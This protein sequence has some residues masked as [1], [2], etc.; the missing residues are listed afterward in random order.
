MHFYLMSHTHMPMAT[1]AE[2]TVVEVT[3][4]AVM[5][6]VAGGE[7]MATVEEVTVRPLRHQLFSF[8]PRLQFLRHLPLPLHHRHLLRLQL[9]L[10]PQF[11]QPLLLHQDVAVGAVVAGAR[12]L[13][14][15]LSPCFR[16][17]AYNRSHIFISHKFHTRVYF[18][19]LFAL[20]YM[21]W[22]PSLL[23]S[24]SHIALF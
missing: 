15:L 4:E 9:R 23:L 17:S 21:L 11:L 13:L 12:L 14:P 19:P 10:H 24:G 20:I 2:E 18:S 3:A 16:M 22:Y 7:E 1:V 8:H 6:A 5:V